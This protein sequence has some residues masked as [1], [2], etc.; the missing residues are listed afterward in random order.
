M[1]VGPQ[2]AKFLAISGELIDA[3]KAKE[4]GLVL[5]VIPHEQFGDKVQDLGRRIASMPPETVMLNRRLINGA[6]EIMGW[7]QQKQL[8]IALNAISN[9]VMDRAATPDGRVLSEI[10][11]DEGWKAFK[12]AR[13]EPFEEPWLEASE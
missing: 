13:D 4:I 2:W 8:T 1:M 9:S 7:T 6:M 12:E 10:L 3:H 11:R 5:E